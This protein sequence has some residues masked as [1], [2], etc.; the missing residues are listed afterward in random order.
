MSTVISFMYTKNSS[1]P[2]IEPWGT[3]RLILSYL[4]NVHL[5]L[6]A[7]FYRPNIIQS[8]EVIFLHSQAVLAS[9]ILN[10]MM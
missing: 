1:D 9:K 5:S 3:Q 4:E 8:D 2:N 6:H 10:W 7:V